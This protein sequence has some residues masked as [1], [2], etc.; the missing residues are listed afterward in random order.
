[1]SL[2]LA[3]NTKFTVSRTGLSVHQELSFDEWAAL[4]PRL[5]EASRCVAFLIGDWL[6]YGE[7]RFNNGTGKPSRRVRSEDYERAISSTGLDR[8]TLHAYAHVAR[9]V[10]PATRLEALSWEHHKA[11][12]KLKSHDQVRWLRIAAESG[13]SVSSR[14][15]RKSI[16]AGRLLS[17][18]ELKLDPADRGIPNHI[19]HINRLRAWWAD[20]KKAHW[21]ECA[22]KVQR[23]RLKR[24]L[25]PVIKIFE[26]L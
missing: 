22:S 10:Q 3:D 2:T 18:A 24:D 4:A 13:G 12:A 20:M 9:K 5:N 14:R 11:V 15:L 21:L 17:V 1:M 8:T 25:L 26:Q 16:T 7:A 19:P 6:I 23:A